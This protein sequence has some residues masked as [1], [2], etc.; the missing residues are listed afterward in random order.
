GICQENQKQSL[1]ENWNDFLHYR[2]I[3]N[4]ELAKGYAHAILDNDPNT[5]ELFTLSQNNPTGYQI[6]VSASTNKYDPELADLSEQ[7]LKL[8][9]KGGYARRSNPNV[10]F[11]EVKRLNSDTPRGRLNA[12]TRLRNA[13]EYAIPF[14]L[15]ALSDPSRQ[16]EFVNIAGALPQIGRDA[17]RPLAAGLQTSNDAVKSEIIKAMGGIRYPQSLPYLKYVIENVQS[18]DLRQSAQSSIMQIDPGALTIPAAQLFYQ[19]AENYYYHAESLTPAEDAPTANIW[20]W[21]AREQK[22]TREAVNKAYFNE[23]MSMRACEWALK[24]DE[25]FGKAI[26]L[27]LAAYFKAESAG[28]GAMPE[29]F[30]QNHAN[31]LVY[32]TTAGVEYLHQALARAVRDGNTFVALGVIEALRNT[33]G[34]KSLFYR[35]GTQQPLVEALSFKDRQVRYSAA[36]AIASAGPQ[37]KFVESK[38]VVTNL[39][40]ALASN[41]QPTVEDASVWNEDLADSYA[42]QAATVMLSLAQ[43][44]NPVIDLSQAEEALINASRDERKQIRILAGHTLAYLQSPTAQ[45]AIVTMALNASDDLDVRI[46]AFNSLAISAKLNTCML[47]DDMINRVYELLSSDQ[48]DPNLRSAAAA[49]Y[50]ALNLP[51]RKVKDLILDQAKS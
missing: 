46:S 30:G 19:L 35:L 50:G 9:E 40:Q 7:L 42:L 2:L 24:A 3:N 12:V 45:T 22:L 6:L 16:D 29:Y 27:W 28:V 14:M 38:L 4:L 37:E 47:S 32:A 15:D 48:T 8:I 49:A 17:I 10:I 21:D 34:E 43:S 1:E 25:S 39:A 41:A 51:S 11:E 31:A 26:G 18:S 23:L 20:F 36:I 13:G 33:A 44:R 5:V